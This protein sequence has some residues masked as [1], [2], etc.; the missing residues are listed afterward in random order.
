[1]L[2]CVLV[3]RFRGGKIGGEE[4][5]HPPVPLGYQTAVEVDKG[6]LPTSQEVCNKESNCPTE[7]EA[8]D[9][10]NGGSCS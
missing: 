10:K 9:A 3:S 6:A 7:L 5:V 2:E 4:I 8:D 1:M